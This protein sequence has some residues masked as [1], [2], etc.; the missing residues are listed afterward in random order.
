MRLS[1]QKPVLL[2]SGQH[3]HLFVHSFFRIKFLYLFFPLAP[4]SFQ[5]PLL[6]PTPLDGQ[7]IAFGNELYVPLTAEQINILYYLVG[8]AKPEGFTPIDDLFTEYKDKLLDWEALEAIKEEFDDKDFRETYEIKSVSN[9]LLKQALDALQAE[10]KAL[11]YLADNED[12]IVDK[13][14][15]IKPDLARQTR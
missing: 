15:E 3:K 6:L 5:L 13:L 4:Q 2:K 11:R 9:A 10:G 8:Y 14:L 1:F 12:E 7:P